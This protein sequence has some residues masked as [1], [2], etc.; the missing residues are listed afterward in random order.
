MW[1]RTLNFV[2]IL[3]DSSYPRD[4]WASLKE[5]YLPEKLQLFKKYGSI[6]PTNF[7]LTEE[8]KDLVLKIQKQ[9][10]AD[11]KRRKRAYDRNEEKDEEQKAKERF[12]FLGNSLAKLWGWNKVCE[13]FAFGVPLWIIC[14]DETDPP[15]SQEGLPNKSMQAIDTIDSVYQN[16]TELLREVQLFKQAS[17]VE[18]FD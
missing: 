17:K 12:A 4:H 7:D 14:H 9:N 13:I 1:W 11:K 3:G 16:K 6:L 2:G 18:L 15:S 8:E 10:S 5:R